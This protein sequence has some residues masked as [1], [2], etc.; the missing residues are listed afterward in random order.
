M[1]FNKGRGRPWLRRSTVVIAATAIA[2]PAGVVGT[3]APAAAANATI[4][5]VTWAATDLREP[6]DVQLEPAGDL[7]VGAWRDEAGRRHVSRAYF[8]FDVEELAG[9]FIY[10][11][12]I[13]LTE[14]AAAECGPQAAGVA[15]H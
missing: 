6:L 12:T 1:V 7:A 4:V 5:N 9:R 2:S 15:D 8:A 11:A 14:T 10:D 3:A 13:V